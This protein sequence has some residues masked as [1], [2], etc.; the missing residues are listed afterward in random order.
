M[1]ASCGATSTPSN[2]RSGPI[3]SRPAPTVRRV[4]LWPS[5]STRRSSRGC[6][7]RGRSARSSSMA[8]GRR[9]APALRP[10]RARRL[11]WSDRPQDYRTEVLGLVKA[12]Q[13]KNAV[14]VPVGAKGGFYPKRCPPAAAATRFSRPGVPPTSFSSR[15][16][17]RSP[18]II[19]GDAVVPP[20]NTVCA[21]TATIPISWSPPT[22]ARRPSPTPP[23]HLARNMDFWLDDAFASGARPAT[24]TRRWASPPAAPGRR[25]SAISARW[26]S[27]SR[28]ALH[29]RRRRR[30]VRRRVRQRHAAVDPDPAGRRLRSPRH[31]H[32]SRSGLPDP[33]LP[34]A[35]AVRSRPLELAGLRQVQ[36]DRRAAASSRARSKSI[37]LTPEAADAIGLDKARRRRTR[38]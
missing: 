11:R 18:T 6:P 3:I 21:M 17:C 29:R 30:H 9:R 34:S 35:S 27:T 16:C 25:S 2:P 12:Q 26:T 28:P 36:A 24:T 20:A 4:R 38:S 1:T 23:T 33:A 7:S 14:I 5:S 32:R 13:V 19:V 37:T 8:G 15:A 10:G 22:R 31:L